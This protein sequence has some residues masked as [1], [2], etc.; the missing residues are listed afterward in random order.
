MA[1]CF[2]SID[3]DR[4]ERRYRPGETVS[5]HVVVEVDASCRCDGLVVQMTWRTHGKGN[6]D[7]KALESFV[8]WNGQWSAGQVQR[9]P[10]RLT[11]PESP[12]AFRGETLN[13]DHYV[14]AT[15]DIP[16]AFDPEANQDILVVHEDGG[17]EVVQNAKAQEAERSGHGCMLWGFGILAVGLSGGVTAA[18]IAGA[19]EAALSMMCPALI[20]MA[21]FA[22]ALKRGL[23]ERK[24]GQVLVDIEQSAA[25]GYRDGAGA[26]ELTC[27][28]HTLASA[29]VTSVVATFVVR[30]EVK[31]G[32]GTNKKTYNHT[33]HTAQMSLTP[34][35]APGDWAARFSLPPAGALP[36]SFAASDNKVIW[37]MQVAIDI[38]SWPDWNETIPLIARPSRAGGRAQVDHV[39]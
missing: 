24:V 28:V 10:F 36:Y 35:G 6:V 25:G 27:T 17:L 23:A 18:V 33:L 26:D 2:L 5:G 31:K 13:L 21:L 32:S 11:A 12:R 15:A 1:N 39:I 19:M 14:R 7:T 9:Y 38:P 16:W 4:P 34:A 8:L 20:F 30:E 29:A 3:L 37:E 22:M